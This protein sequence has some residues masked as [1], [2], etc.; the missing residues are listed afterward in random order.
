MA[1]A[2]NELILDLSEE[3]V[4]REVLGIVRPTTS[5]SYKE[6]RDA[7]LV[8][9]FFTFKDDWE[10]FSGGMARRLD[11]YLAE[12]Q[13]PSKNQLSHFR[14]AFMNAL[15]TS[16]AAFREH[17][18]RRYVPDKD[19]WRKPILAALYDANMFAAM[20]YTPAQTDTR[21]SQLEQHAYKAL[22]SDTDFRRSIDAATNTPALFRSTCERC[23]SSSLSTLRSPWRRKPSSTTSARAGC[24][25]TAVDRGPISRPTAT[26]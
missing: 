23:E 4:F 19:Q 20:D 5:G 17:A 12:N 6:I 13:R 1:G 15:L 24:A 2:S 16:Q 10:T 21:H 22:L 7:E 11:E 3:P 9:R 8:L 25:A 14:D 18:F 26:S